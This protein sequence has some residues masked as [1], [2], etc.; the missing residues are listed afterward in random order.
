MS[1]IKSGKTLSNVGPSL[2]NLFDFGSFFEP[3]FANGGLMPAVNVKE[4]PS[5]YE[6]EMAAP[7]RSKKDFNISISEGV[8]S[9]S[10][11]KEESKEE[12]EKNYTRKEFSYHSFK[13]SFSLPKGIDEEN[14]K[15]NYKEGVLIIKVAKKKE[16]KPAVKKE[17]KVS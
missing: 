9:I 15:A 16:A 8:L 4:N 12:E 3:D 14:I 17:I 2:L 11:E 6:I 7:G 1:L 5:D 13:R 10:S